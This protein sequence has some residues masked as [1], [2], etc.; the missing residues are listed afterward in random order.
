MLPLIYLSRFLRLKLTPPKEDVLLHCF[1][2]IAV[3]YYHGVL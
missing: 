1:F 3:L 2:N